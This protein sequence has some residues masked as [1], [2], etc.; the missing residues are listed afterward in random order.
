MKLQV[1]KAQKIDQMGSIK[2]NERGRDACNLNV[3]S[4]IYGASKKG[5]LIQMTNKTNTY[6][7]KNKLFTPSAELKSLNVEFS[8]KA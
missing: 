5:K 3:Q 8:N 1:T 6:N 2:K 4:Y 7:M